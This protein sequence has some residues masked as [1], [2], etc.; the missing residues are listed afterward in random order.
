ML[1]V[2]S[3]HIL[4]YTVLCNELHFDEIQCFYAY[5]CNESTGVGNGALF[6]YLF[7]L[8]RAAP[9]AYRGS[10]VR[11]LIRAVAAGLRHSHSNA[12][13]EPSL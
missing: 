7:L 2:Y 5:I 3:F 10:Q 12:R 9:V 1:G 11:G 13:S 6:I 8:F 4:N